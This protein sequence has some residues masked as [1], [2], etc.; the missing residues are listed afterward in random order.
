MITSAGHG[1]TNGQLV[2]NIAGVVGMTNLNGNSYYANNVST[3]SFQLYTDAGLTTTLD[4]TGFN[5]YTSG[6]TMEKITQGVAF[7]TA[8][9]IKFKEVKSNIANI[10]TNIQPATNHRLVVNQTRKGYTGQTIKVS[11]RNSG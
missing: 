3:N 8:S 4:G 9:L 1:Y 6:G 10:Q 11:V 5:A 2:Q 7:G